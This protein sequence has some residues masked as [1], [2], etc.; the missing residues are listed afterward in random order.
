MLRHGHGA[1]AALEAWQKQ[2]AQ[3]LPEAAALV[4]AAGAGHAAGISSLPP[5]EAAK[6]AVVAFGGTA[7][8]GV[9]PLATFANG[10]IHCVQR[11]STVRPPAQLPSEASLDSTKSDATGS[12]DHL[13]NPMHVMCDVL[14][15]APE[16]ACL[17][18]RQDVNPFLL[19]ATHQMGGQDAKRHR[20]REVGLW[21][22]APEYYETGRYVEMRDFLAPTRPSTF[23]RW[24]TDRMVEFHVAAV[25]QQLGQVCCM[26]EPCL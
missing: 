12:E 7:S 4:A 8:L 23:Y 21:N 1:A 25:R 9:L 6:H 20:L 22:D 13:L 11:L 14:C 19:H 16:A 24:P 26:T 5:S 2:M 10:H 17:L 18:Q 3:G 15:H